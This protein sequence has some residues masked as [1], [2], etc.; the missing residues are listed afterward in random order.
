MDASLLERVPP[1]SKEA[2]QATLGAMLMERE[3]IARVVDILDPE[4]FYSPQ[5]QMVYRAMIDL[6]NDSDPV[7]LITLQARL[8][9]RDQLQE[10]GG[11]PYLATLQETASTAAAISHYAKIVREKSILRALIRAGGEIRSLAH[12]AADEDVESVVDRCEQEVFSVG[13]RTITPAFTPI[14]DLLGETY[15]RIDEMQESHRPGTG[16]LTGY[17]DLDSYLSGLQASDL[18]VVAARPSMGKTAL[19]LNIACYVAKTQ[20]KTVAVF[21][22]EM[23][24]EQLA[25]RLLCSEAGVN[26]QSVRQGYIDRGDMDRIAIAASELYKTPVYLDD[27]ATMSVLQIRGKARRLRAEH[28]LDLIIVDYIQLVSGYG[29]F[30]NR[31]QEISQVARSLKALAREL[32]V[33]VVALSQLSR[34]VEA[35]GHP[36]RPLLSDLR[37]SGSIEQEADVVG[38]IY[39]PMYYGPEELRA[40]GYLETDRNLAEIIIAKQRNGPTG[41]VRLAWVDEFVRFENLEERFAEPEG[42]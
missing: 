37:E 36:R 40:A 42:E 28:G 7:D 3:A 18:V 38:F 33:P 27:T 22:L 31:N 5:H 30:E 6:F 41:I 39:R 20:N 10:I 11:T 4:D 32:R 35:R 1:Q 8:Q 2:E 25:L 24:K 17:D 29:R 34:A 26:Q 16:L 15:D 14:R 9:D 19:A 12:S 21:S 23:A 13:E